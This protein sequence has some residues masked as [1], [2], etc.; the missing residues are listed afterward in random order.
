VAITLA[1]YDTATIT[2]IKSFRVQAPRD[3]KD[4]K[5]KFFVKKICE[6]SSQPFYFFLSFKAKTEMR[7]F[8]GY[9]QGPEAI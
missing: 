7:S 5:I 6:N 8:K 1:C 3:R 4:R 9:L 2:A